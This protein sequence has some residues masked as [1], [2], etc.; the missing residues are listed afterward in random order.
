MLREFVGRLAARRKNYL[1]TAIHKPS[2]DVWSQ[3]SPA[4]LGRLWRGRS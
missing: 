4:P 3:T 1:M 2:H